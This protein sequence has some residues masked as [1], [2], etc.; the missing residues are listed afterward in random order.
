LGLK[1]NMALEFDK[2]V[3]MLEEYIEI[4]K[5]E[6][7]FAM[8]ERKPQNTTRIIRIKGELDKAVQEKMKLSQIYCRPLLISS[9]R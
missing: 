4:L 5:Q 9:S 7:L 2:A 1:E 3:E 8:A 6:L